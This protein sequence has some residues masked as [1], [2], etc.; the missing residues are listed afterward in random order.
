MNIKLICTLT[1]LSLCIIFGF[2]QLSYSLDKTSQHNISELKILKYIPRDNK[3]LFISNSKSSQII[4]NIQQSY[5]NKDQKS[6]KLIKNSI[7]A[8]L[9]I[10]IGPQNLEDIYENELVIITSDNKEKN[11]EDIL[12]VFKMNAEKDIDDLLNLTNKID[13]ANKLIKIY[14]KN[15]LNYL[16]YIYRTDDNYIITS[17]SKSLIDKALE[18]CKINENNVTKNPYFKQILINFKNENNVLFTKEFEANKLLN[19][20]KYLKTEDDYIATLFNFKDKKIILKSYLINDKKNVDL[21][22]YKKVI[23]DHIF[24]NNNYQVVIYDDLFNSIEY[25]NLDKAE[26]AFL[27]ELDEKLKQEILVLVSES[28]W[29]IIFDKNNKNYMSIDNT[30]FL[31]DFT[32]YSLE[33]NDFVYKIYSKNIL[34]NDENIIKKEIYKNIFSAESDEFTFVSNNLIND[35]EL[36]SAS[37]EFLDYQSKIY[38]RYFLDKKIDLKKPVYNTYQN[39]SYLDNINCFFKNHINILPIEFKAIMQQSIPDKTPIYYSETYLEIL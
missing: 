11:I 13:E 23:K 31:K 6:L 37:K 28:N 3:T 22:S 10:D 12:I 24:D 26:K 14:R 1:I 36:D 27:K 25:I 30:K 5:K 34:K 7:L 35:I 4:S 8:Y 2:E 29:L 20:E 21:V 17:S 18:A 33:N 38:P 19:N 39:I 16:N 15:K 9:G 32:K